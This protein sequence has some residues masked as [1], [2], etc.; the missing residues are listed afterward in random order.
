MKYE[1][2]FDENKSIKKIVI[3]NGIVNIGDEYGYQKIK[4]NF[5]KGIVKFLF[6]NKIYY[7]YDISCI[8]NCNHEIN[9]RNTIINIWI[10]FYDEKFKILNKL[11]IKDIINI[12]IQYLF[13]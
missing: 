13:Y 5:V 4:L 6:K 12:I 11:F 1:I 7:N 8:F 2:T 10:K 3:N 9:I